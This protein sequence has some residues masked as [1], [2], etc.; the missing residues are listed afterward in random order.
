MGKVEIRRGEFAAS[1]HYQ[2]YCISLLQRDLR[3]AK[4]FC[5]NKILFCRLNSAG[6]HD[7]QAVSAEVS[8]AVEA[9]SRNPRLIADN[10]AP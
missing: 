6:I 3:L 8:F 4:D 5:R 1:V 2:D 9:V 10:G 7:A